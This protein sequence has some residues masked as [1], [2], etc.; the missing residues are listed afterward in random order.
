M[1]ARNLDL[2][3]WIGAA[4]MLIDHFWLY[5]FGATVASEAIGSLAFPLFAVA[6]AQ[7]TA[8]QHYGSRVRTL[9]RLA[10]G[11]VAAQGAVLVVREFLPLNVIFTLAAGIALDTA[12]RYELPRLHRVTL[13]LAAVAVGFVAEYLHFGALLVWALCWLA[14]T[15]SVRALVAAAVLLC[16]VAPLN[17]NW[18]A[19]AAPAVLYFVS[20]IPRDTPRLKD[21]FYYVYVLQWPLIAATAHVLTAW[22]RT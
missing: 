8:T 19:L 9:Q 13:V 11:A 3:K 14:R 4:A 5:V 6:L 16:V 21:A 18:W 10:L 1:R 22:G 7:G 17:A 2:L 12:T 15:Q 20:L